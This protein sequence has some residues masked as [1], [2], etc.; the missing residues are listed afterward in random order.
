MEAGFI[1]AE[2]IA[3]AALLG[4][5]TEAAARADGALRTEGR[6]YPVQD[7][8]VLRILFR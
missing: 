5:G 7:G 8:D 3:A 1:R 2:V 6:D 4:Y